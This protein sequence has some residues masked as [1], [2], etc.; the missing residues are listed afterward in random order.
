MKI[1]IRQ[2]FPDDFFMLDGERVAGITA[3]ALNS[4]SYGEITGIGRLTAEAS[5][6]FSAYRFTVSVDGVVAYVFRKNFWGKLFDRRRDITLWAGQILVS[7]ETVGRL[8]RAKENW[9]KPMFY[10]DLSERA[11]LPVAVAY[12]PYAIGQRQI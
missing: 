6:L 12:L 7:G 4:S 3:N 9:L 11:F 8:I 10:L 5:G 1:T 2:Q